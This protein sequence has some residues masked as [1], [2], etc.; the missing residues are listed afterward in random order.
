MMLIP[1]VTLKAYAIN[2][3]IT[4][5]DLPLNGALPP[6]QTAINVIDKILSVLKNNQLYNT[7]G[8][9]NGSKVNDIES[10]T[11]ILHK[12]VNE[13]QALGNHTF[14]HLDLSKIETEAYIEDIKKNHNLLSSITNPTSVKYFSYPYLAE[15]NTQE[16]RDN[17]RSY[18]FANKFSIAQVSMDF[19]EY[20][21]APAY[22]RCI[23]KG[24][25]R[26]IKWLRKSYL[27]QVVN[28]I[29]ISHELSELLFGRDIQY[30]LLLHANA[31]TAM[32]LE[33]L[34]VT[35]KHHNVNFISLQ[36]ALSDSIYTINPNIIENRAYTFLNQIR[37][38]L[39]LE[40][41]D[42]VKK[43]YSS[44]PEKKLTEI[45]SKESAY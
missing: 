16:K 29:T 18:L 12:W 8:F 2:V 6:E 5:D 20:L 24:D 41:P 10:G 3:A 36:E 35:M 27:E 44:L 17:V 30:I 21:W 32:M 22:I 4:F 43:L 13:H 9:V 40:N 39:G 28:S 31:F 37:L 34:I 45:C 23:Q 26:A 14:S 11:D 33:E 25:A 42:I 15:G 7:Y 38:S 19:F 1:L